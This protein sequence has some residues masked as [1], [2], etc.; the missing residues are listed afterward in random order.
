MSTNFSS[1]KEF[2]KDRQ[3]YINIALN[4]DKRI[5]I[6]MLV[7]IIDSHEYILAGQTGGIISLYKDFP[8]EIMLDLKAVNM[9]K[10][11]NVIKEFISKYGLKEED[12]S[13]ENNSTNFRLMIRPTKMISKFI[14]DNTIGAVREKKMNELGL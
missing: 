10:D 7:F 2:I 11:E 12:Y 8:K 5:Q 4:S 13:L 1:E 6:L 9:S 3:R 14:Q